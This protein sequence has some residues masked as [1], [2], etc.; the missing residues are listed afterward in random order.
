MQDFQI[1]KSESEGDSDTD[2][3][4]STKVLKIIHPEVH[5][6]MKQDED[7]KKHVDRYIAVFKMCTLLK[8]SGSS[9]IKNVVYKTQQSSFQNGLNMNIID[10]F[11]GLR[12]TCTILHVACSL[13]KLQAK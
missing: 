1:S 9:T 2:G 10:L 6:L 5:K 3:I 11:E 7:R 8:D 13:E 12:F 4:E